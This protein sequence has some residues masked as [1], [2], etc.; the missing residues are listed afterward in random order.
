MTP[1]ALAFLLALG[2]LAGCSR[3]APEPHGQATPAAATPERPR[4]S[5]PDSS[6][7]VTVAAD[8]L[9]DLR[10]TTATVESRAAGERLTLLGELSVDERA[11]AQ[12]GVPVAARV[13]RLLAGAGDRVAAGQA[14]AEVTSPELGRARAE[15]VSAAARVAL[16][17]AALER[18]RGLAAE[19]IVPVREVQEAESA[20][21][22]A[23]AAQR[24]ARAAIGAY[25]VDPPAA[26]APE[27]TSSSFFLRSP[28]AGTVIERSAVVGQMLDASTPAFT[29]GDLSRLW[30]TVHAFER[31]AVRVESGA[32]ATMT[33]AALP[34]REFGGVVSLV[35]RSV[36]RESR[37]VP[38][39][40]D[41]RNDGRL[42]R[43]G[44]SGAASIPIGAADGPALTVPVA[45]VQRL[46]NAWCVFVPRG[47]GS[48]EIRA[49]GRGRDLGGEVEVL[50]G[51]RAGETVVVDGAFLLKAEAEK[52]D[53]D[54]EDH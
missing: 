54:H 4:G 16:T 3:P 7:S 37:T 46:G 53:A 18:K 17:E 42:L 36:E 30:L 22:E 13:T 19:R 40:V 23:R 8:M 44:M 6:R 20:A 49:I 43:P 27:A 28:L 2:S 26:D 34:G 51:L 45:A 24:M 1:R 12:V 39:R 25:G 41:V 11:Y 32:A 21:V 29:L 5:E 31:D 14:L 48:F 9:R 38:V 47:E 15:Y 35:G 50:S 10:V 52:G 33:F